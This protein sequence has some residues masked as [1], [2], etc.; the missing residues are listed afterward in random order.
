MIKKIWV[1]DEREMPYDY[2]Y[3]ACSVNYVLCLIRDFYYYDYDI[4]VSLDHDAGKYVGLGGD[5]IKILERLEETCYENPN[6]RD[7]IRDKVIF[8]LHTANPVGRE[9]M[10]RIIQKNGWKEV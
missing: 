10:R 9:N 6:F 3:P 2:T 7:Y 4:E 1:D 8:H 5:Y